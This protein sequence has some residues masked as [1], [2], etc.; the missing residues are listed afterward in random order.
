MNLFRTISPHMVAYIVQGTA[1]QGSEIT[2]SGIEACFAIFWNLFSVKMQ[3]ECFKRSLRLSSWLKC[4][5]EFSWKLS[6]QQNLSLQC[7]NRAPKQQPKEKWKQSASWDQNCMGRTLAVGK[8]Y[9]K[10]GA[11]PAVSLDFSRLPFVNYQNDKKNQLL[12]K[13]KMIALLL[14]NLWGGCFIQKENHST[15]RRPSG[16]PAFGPL[17]QLKISAL[18]TFI[19]SLCPCAVISSL[20]EVL[21]LYLW[22]PPLAKKRINP[23]CLKKIMFS[24]GLIPQKFFRRALKEYDSYFC[25]QQQTCKLNPRNRNACRFCRY[26][27][28]LDVGMSRT[29]I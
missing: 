5:I 29:G 2:C 17:T 28:C 21:N 22:T 3:S 9:D 24:L 13:L 7:C 18:C 27:K 14:C 25:K 19:C 12:P 6:D 16:L 10:P 11:C 8:S 20:Q 23:S 4:K 26:K 1:Q 15:P